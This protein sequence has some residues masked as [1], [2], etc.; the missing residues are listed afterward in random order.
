MTVPNCSGPLFTDLYELTMAAGYFE[1]RMT[2]SSTFSLYIRGYP[3]NRNYYVATGLE[4]AL[5][6]MENLQFLPRDIEYLR[7]SELFS[8]PFLDYLKTFRFSGTVYALSEGSTGS[9]R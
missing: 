7:D 9:C 5:Q 3:S 1:H 8:E 6:E 4:D 2:S